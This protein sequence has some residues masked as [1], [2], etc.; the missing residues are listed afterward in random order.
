MARLKVELVKEREQA[1]MEAFKT[2]ATQ[3]D[4]N[5]ALQ[6]KYGKRMGNRRLK[7][8]KKLAFE[9]APVSDIIDP[10]TLADTAT[11]V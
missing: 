2:G 9:V 6:A 1:A 10:A 11:E 4:V 3:A 7:E 8:L 5:R